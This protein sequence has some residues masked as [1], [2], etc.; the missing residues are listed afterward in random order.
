MPPLDTIQ[1]SEFNPHSH[2]LFTAYFNFILPSTFW[3]P[4]WLLPVRI[5]N[6]NSLVHKLLIRSRLG[7][8]LTQQLHSALVLLFGHWWVTNCCTRAR[9]QSR[10]ESRAVGSRRLGSERVSWRLPARESP[11]SSNQF[12]SVRIVRPLA[13]LSGIIKTCRLLQHSSSFHWIPLW[14]TAQYYTVQ[15]FFI[16]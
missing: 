5:S 12:L 1:K 16:T 10:T 2:S 7:S 6:W 11:R 8:H 15:H 4:E 14:K 13:P 9:R 3:S